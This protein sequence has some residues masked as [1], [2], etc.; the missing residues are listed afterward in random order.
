MENFTTGI[1][2]KILFP[3]LREIYRRVHRLSRKSFRIPPI[4]IG[5]NH[6][7]STSDDCIG[8]VLCMHILSDD[9]TI[10]IR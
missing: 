1:L 2:K 10:G 4:F 6:V 9:A 5:M 7:P 8:C 3:A